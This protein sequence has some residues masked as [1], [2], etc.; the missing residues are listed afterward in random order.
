MNLG[1]EKNKSFENKTGQSRFVDLR[2]LSCFVLLN[3][4]YSNY[5]AWRDAFMSEQNIIVAEPS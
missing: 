2:N 3:Q 4:D 1:K 5:Q